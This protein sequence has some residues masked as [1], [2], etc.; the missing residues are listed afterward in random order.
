MSA[1]LA[2]LRKSS[3]GT[4]A[5]EGKPDARQGIFRV[6]NLNVGSH[7]ELTFR[8]LEIKQNE[9]RETACDFNWSTQHID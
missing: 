3:I 8:S 4:S 2:D 6:L 1:L 7:R 5:N 9:G